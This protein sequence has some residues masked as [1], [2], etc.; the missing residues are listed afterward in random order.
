MFSCYNNLVAIMN[1]LSWSLVILLDLKYI[2]SDINVVTPA[3]LYFLF[4]WCILLR[5]IKNNNKDV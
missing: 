1:Y 2:S 5:V 4:E 3:F